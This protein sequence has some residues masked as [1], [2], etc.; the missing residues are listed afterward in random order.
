[1][2]LPSSLSRLTLILFLFL[3]ALPELPAQMPTGTEFIVAIPAL[4]RR[5]ELIDEADIRIMVMAAR[6]TRVQL[7]WSGPNGS[8][9][10]QL[11]VQAGGRSMFSTPMLFQVPNIIQLNFD[12]V[13][14]EVNQRSFIVESDHPVSVFLLYDNYAETEI[15]R[16]SKTEMWSVPPIDTYDTS[17]VVATGSG[18]AD[19]GDRTGFLIVAA[20]DNTTVDW[21][22]S[23][24]WGYVSPSTRYREPSR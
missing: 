9:I 17:F 8:L 6:E 1:M 2:R 10:D 23:V 13:P 20:E 19:V 7:R 16:R 3:F 15:N 12:R 18:S 4:W 11:I 5:A 14:V 22:P 24:R 21:T